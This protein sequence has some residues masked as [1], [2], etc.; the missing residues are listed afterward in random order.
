MLLTGIVQFQK[1]SIPTQRSLEIPGGRGVLKVN[2]LKEKYEAKLEFHRGMGDAKQKNLLWWEYGY[3]L[4]GTL[5]SLISWKGMVGVHLLIILALC[6][7]IVMWHKI[8]DMS[9]I[10]NESTLK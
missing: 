10:D 9:S 2:S 5:Q 8:L 3:F 1:K 7:M 6:G 4:E